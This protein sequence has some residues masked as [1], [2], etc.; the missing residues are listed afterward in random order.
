MLFNLQIRANDSLSKLG[1]HRKGAVSSSVNRIFRNLAVMELSH[2][3]G[4]T[5]STKSLRL[6]RFI[7]VRLTQRELWRV[8]SGY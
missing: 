2:P 5:R 8:S 3:N 4:N 7:G 1:I 6:L